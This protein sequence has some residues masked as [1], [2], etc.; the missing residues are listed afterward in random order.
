MCVMVQSCEMISIDGI[1]CD[2]FTY[3]IVPHH[4]WMQ[5][6]IGLKWICLMSKYYLEMAVSGGGGIFLFVCH[7]K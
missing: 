3:I 4:S 5:S 1:V 2:H 7:D 6:T